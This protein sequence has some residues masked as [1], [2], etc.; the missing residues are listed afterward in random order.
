MIYNK[1]NIFLPTKGR[2][3]NGK[4]NRFLLSAKNKCDDY[5]SI[6]IT[7]LLDKEDRETINFIYSLELKIE[8]SVLYY[9]KN[10]VHL[11]KFYNYIY[12]NT[13]F[14]EPETVVTM[15]GDDMEFITQGYDTKVLKEINKHDGNAVVY[16]ND[17]NQGRKLCAN[18]FTTREVVEWTRHPFMCE[19]FGAY[20]IDTVWMRVA[21]KLKILYYLEDVLIIHHHYTKEGS[22]DQTSVGLDKVKLPF[23]FGLKK[24]DSYVKEV[25]RCVK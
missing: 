9:P 3:Q 12:N 19:A 11:G 4:L 15:V 25:I 10:E 1:I 7:F 18:I 5:R 22:K 14:S 21:E 23:N 20:F 13:I 2:V 8:F 16:C 17:R 24:V 6:C